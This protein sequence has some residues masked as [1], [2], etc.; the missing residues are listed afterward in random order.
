M[1]LISNKIL[2]AFLLL[3]EK[4]MFHSPQEDYKIKRE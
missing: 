1:A 2:A 3:I 4:F